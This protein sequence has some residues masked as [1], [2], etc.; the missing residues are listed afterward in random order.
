MYIKSIDKSSNKLV[1]HFRIND[2]FGN[3]GEIEV[4][5]K[6]SSG[7]GKEIIKRVGPTENFDRWMWSEQLPKM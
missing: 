1:V 7:S 3:Y 5:V 2:T 4:R 6:P